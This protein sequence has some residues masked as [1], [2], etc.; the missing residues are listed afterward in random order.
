MDT[1]SSREPSSSPLPLIGAIAGVLGLVLGIVALVKVSGVNQAVTE[2]GDSIGQISAIKSTADSAASTATKAASDLTKM[3]NQTNTAL[4]QV[5]NLLSEHQTRLAKL[6]E[7]PAP[8]AAASGGGSN[9]P[10]V[11]GPNEYVIK[12]GDT[13]TGIARAQGVT[14]ADLMAVNPDVDPRR[15]MVGQKIKLPQQ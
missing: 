14:L 15:M 13:L 3:A 2:Q 7:S 8:Q 10:V 4:Q 6:E 1:I 5:G 11:A 9:G 12:S